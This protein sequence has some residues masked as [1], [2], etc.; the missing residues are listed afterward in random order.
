MVEKRFAFLTLLCIVSVVLSSLNFYLILD[1]INVREQQFNE[2]E[3]NI[4]H[5]QSSI[6][7]INDYI[8]DLNITDLYSQL[9]KLA[10]E[11]EELEVRMPEKTSSD[12]Y[13]SAY[14]SVVTIR[15]ST[16]QG[17]GFLYGNQNLVLTNWHVVEF[18]EE[19]EVQ[20][21]DRTR[22]EA[23]LVGGDKY[24]D[25]AVLKVDQTPSDA[26]P[27]ELANSSKVWIGQDVVAIG[28][29]L[30]L[31]GS[32]SIGIISQVNKRIDLPP[33]I[34][35][36]L[37]LDITVAP[38]SSG[39]PLLDLHGSVVGITNAGTSAGFNFAIPSNIVE[40]AATSIIESGSYKHP[41]VGFSGIELSPS[42]VRDLNILNIDAFQPGI[43]IWEIFPDTP[44]EEAGLRGVIETQDQ[45]GLAAYEARDIILEVDGQP[46]YSFEDWGAYIEE[47]V[48]PG[49]TINLILWRSEEIVSLDIVTTFRPE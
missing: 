23:T 49:Q 17:S 14:R 30:G 48:S 43:L 9:T 15:T 11:L 5:I 38:G 44:A 32:L 21:Y 2:V 25:V 46:M 37:Q 29:P 7:T 3:N 45:H 39:G 28:N 41:F 4:L 33:L 8:D 34:I 19:I 22:I 12:I 27:L 6:S 16:A 36:V 24:S 1:L 18:E 42:A 20:F 47:N 31:T 10:A 35:P 40:R 13:E 26:L